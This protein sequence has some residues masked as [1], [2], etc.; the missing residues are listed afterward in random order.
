MEKEGNDCR[1][2]IYR[3]GFPSQLKPMLRAEKVQML[4]YPDHRP[5]QKGE[6]ADEQAISYSPILQVAIE[7]AF[8]PPASSYTHF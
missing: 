8:K 4:A 7:Y 1:V 3:D 6:S 2:S 5:L